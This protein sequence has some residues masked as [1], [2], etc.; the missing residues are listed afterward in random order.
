MRFIKTTLHRVNHVLG[1]CS[2]GLNPLRAVKMEKRGRGG[3]SLSFEERQTTLIMTT[4]LTTRLSKL[5]YQRSAPNSRV[6]VLTQ[7][8]KRPRT[9]YR[10]KFI[11]IQQTSVDSGGKKS[12]TRP[13]MIGHAP[14]NPTT[15]Q[16]YNG[17]VL[18]N[19]FCRI[20]GKTR[21]S[22]NRG[23]PVEPVVIPLGCIPLIATRTGLPAALMKF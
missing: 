22:A 20:H 9:S 5:P 12:G 7:S 4:T 18:L 10:G 21:I 15:H 2:R 13:Q 16:P 23:G 14:L 19:G 8:R 1:P 6:A 17:T 11:H 3:R